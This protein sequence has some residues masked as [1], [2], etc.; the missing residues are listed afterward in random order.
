M[1]EQSLKKYVKKILSEI[2][3]DN[4]E[5]PDIKNLTLE[6]LFEILEDLGF[7]N[8]EK[9]SANFFKILV[10]GT[11]QDRINM[12]AHITSELQNM[13]LDANW[14]K[15]GHG[16]SLGRIELG[17]FKFVIKPLSRQ[18]QSSAGVG[19]EAYL[20]TKVNEYASEDSPVTIL[21]KSPER[22]FEI[23]DVVRVHHAGHDTKGRKKSDVNF[24]TLGGSEIPISIK[25]EN[26]EYWESADVYWRDNGEKLIQQIVDGN[27]PGVQINPK[28]HYFVVV[29]N[30]AVEATDE[31]AEHVVF[32]S[33]LGGK[34]AIITATFTPDNFNFDEEN[35]GLEI[36]VA[37][38]I[39]DIKHVL[40]DKGV[41]FLIRNDSK[42]RGFK[43]YP[44][45]RVL[46]AYNKRV[47][48]V[49]KITKDQRGKFGLSESRIRQIIYE[50]LTRSDETR[51]QSL[52]RQVAKEEMRKA[53]GGGTFKQA[54][55]AEIIKALGKRA[56]KQ[57]IAEITKAV[58]IK[59][60]RELSYS[61]RPVIDRIKV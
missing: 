30:I 6:E 2:N 18:G 54:I 4:T 21:F 56:T 9:K 48:N 22:E 23:K 8:T 7:S 61:Y 51:I 41:W 31:E 19:N 32:G 27:V 60:Y 53:F 16:S 14:D 20:V 35:G 34:G 55:E 5:V 37:H 58:L 26:A 39:T 47:K 43:S 46:A 57:E 45:L 40:D 3:D 49:H 29:P 17:K 44:G 13:G 52:A 33:D 36:S 10:D 1:P 12:Y 59:L 24:E 15:G 50:E 25:Q 42:R 28:E 38:I 11:Y